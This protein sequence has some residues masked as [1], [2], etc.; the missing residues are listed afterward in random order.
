MEL[1]TSDDDVSLRISNH[2]KELR[3]WIDDYNHNEQLSSSMSNE[4]RMEISKRQGD[5]GSEAIILRVPEAVT[6]KPFVPESRRIEETNFKA[7]P[8]LKRSPEFEQ[9]LSAT[10]ELPNFST[11]FPSRQSNFYRDVPPKPIRKPVKWVIESK[12]KKTTISLSPTNDKSFSHTQNGEIIPLNV[13]TQP[14]K[15]TN[16]LSSPF[17]NINQTKTNPLHYPMTPQASRNVN[18]FSPTN[19]QLKCDFNQEIF[20]PQALERALNSTVMPR[21]LSPNRMSPY[22]SSEPRLSTIDAFEILRKSIKETKYTTAVFE[23][24][25]GGLAPIL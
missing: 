21:Y 16:R 18:N 4:Q 14:P 9:T 19:Y 22:C 5:I 12:A 2:L 25:F 6:G 10:P 8:I 3:Q 13:D 17:T 11:K 1:A 23:S 20:S 24:G 7:H 15:V